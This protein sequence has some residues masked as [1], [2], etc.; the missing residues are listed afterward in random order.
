MKPLLLFISLSLLLSCQFSKG[1]KKDLGTGLSASYN[2][3]ALEDVYLVSGA[4]DTRLSNNK[5]TLGN[6]V[7]IVVTGVDHYAEQN[8]VVFPGCTIILKDKTGKELLN[9]PNAFEHLKDGQPKAE[10]STLKAILTTGDPM[11]AGETYHLEA[12]F[13]DL[14]KKENTIMTNVDLVAQ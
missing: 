13:Y 14:H 6:K 5:I 8:G 7:S 3:F 1:V 11:V 4:E 10:A 2:G 9:L 12:R